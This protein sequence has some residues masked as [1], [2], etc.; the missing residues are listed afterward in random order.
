MYVT[1]SLIDDVV[2]LTV[3]E[4]ALFIRRLRY[5]HNFTGKKQSLASGIKHQTASLCIY[6]TRVY[7][8]RPVVSSRLS[9]ALKKDVIRV[10][11]YTHSSVLYTSGLWSLEHGLTV[12][13]GLG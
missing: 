1:E 9:S 7:N 8:I 4:T 2:T 12:T 6:S 13:T 3:R 5:V 11:K 10:H